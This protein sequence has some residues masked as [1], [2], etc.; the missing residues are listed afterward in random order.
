MEK[1]TE[2]ERIILENTDERYKY[3]A[4]DSNDELYLY[5][6]KPF[7]KGSIWNCDGDGESEVLRAFNHLFQS[8]QWEDKEP[9]QFRND[10]GEF[11]L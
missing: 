8:I 4:R 7:K 6:I 3:I 2:I 5:S 11:L 10:K 9:L 1:L